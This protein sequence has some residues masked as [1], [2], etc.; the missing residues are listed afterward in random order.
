M[1]LTEISAQNYLSHRGLNIV[2]APET[3]VLLIA[4]PNG[5]GKTAVSQAIK[6]C[7]TGEPTRGLQY[8]KDLV[9]LITQGERDGI[10]YVTYEDSGSEFEHSLN[11][12]TAACSAPGFDY[13]PV[14]LDP[15]EFFAMDAPT[16]RKL[17]FAAAGLK[18]STET[19]RE[20]LVSKGHDP[21][22]VAR[23]V[24]YLRLGF[25]AAATE[26]KTAATEARGA[27]KQIT[28]ETYGEVKAVGWKAYAQRSRTR[29]PSMYCKAQW[30]R[31]RSRGQR[32]NRRARGVARRRDTL[33]RAEKAIKAKGALTVNT[34]AA[35][36]LEAQRAALQLDVDKL[37]QTAQH[38]GGETAPCPACGTVLFWNAKGELK[39]WE[40]AKPAQSPIDAHKLLAEKRAELKRILDGL[41]IA[42]DAVADG[43]AAQTL[44]ENLP[45]TPSAEAI[46]KAENDLAGC[47]RDP[48][49]RARRS[50]KP[51]ARARR[52]GQSRGQDRE[53]CAGARERHR[54]RKP[55][56]CLDQSAGRVSDQD[57]ERG[58]R[59]M[60]RGVQRL[61]QSGRGR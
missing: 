26:A 20:T 2:I 5:I 58:Q 60:Q 55:C 10:V 53:R 9:E 16:R 29:R 51:P 57:A 31:S 14:S 45:K 13:R 27:W 41:D 43:K 34:K 8:K 50:G 37:A 49:A 12:R 3:R 38:S 24:Q 32:K 61:R 39:E 7:L 30:T 17:L 11:L 56:R 22:R 15:A 19:I 59:A 52:T 1:R 36:E 23:A 48:I 18:L 6:L 44:L 54:L 40:K 35:N 33:K 47:K 4:G 21:D 42:K 46:K 28:G 25:D